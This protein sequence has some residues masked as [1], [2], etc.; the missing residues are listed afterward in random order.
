LSEHGTKADALATLAAAR[1]WAQERNAGN[2]SAAR[3]Y[4]AG[5]G[6]FQERIPQNMLGGRFLTES[7]RM[8]AEWADWG[9]A[10]VQDWPDDVSQSWTRAL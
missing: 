3:A 6:P 5:V 1:A 10:I 7:Y 4:L 9:T 2:K 8:V